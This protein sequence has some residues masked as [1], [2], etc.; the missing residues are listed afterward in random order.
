MMKHLRHQSWAVNAWFRSIGLKPEVR[1]SLVPQVC[2]VQ[3][4]DH[5]KARQSNPGPKDVKN[6]VIFIT[7]GNSG[8]GLATAKLFAQH[9]ASV[10]VFGRRSSQNEATKQEIENSGGRCLALTGDV[11]SRSDLEAVLTH[12]MQTFGAVH[13]AFNNAGTEQDFT[14][15]AQQ[16]DDD[17]RRIIDTNVRGTWLAMQ[18]EIPLITASGG[19]AVVNMASVL[20][21]VGLPHLSLYTASKHA[22]I[23]LTRSIAKEYA[24]SAVRINSVSPGA[25]DTQMYRR[26]LTKNPGMAAAM[27]D[28]HPLGRIGAVEDV[29]SAVLYLCRD[30]VGTN[31][32]DILLDGGYTTVF[33]Q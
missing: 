18:L 24:N 30:A 19:G 27:P 22:I 20:G 15:L 4:A 17:Y 7:G 3:A 21:R 12:T 16:S 33:G 29:A 13:Y 26:T 32:Q 11:T 14:P 28:L 2:V 6:K 31:G 8:I 25:I 10:A 5:R 23:G 1:K 9:G